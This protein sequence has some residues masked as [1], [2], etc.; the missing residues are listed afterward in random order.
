MPVVENW[1]CW[2]KT[3]CWV[4]LRQIKENK[5][6]ATC[7][8]YT[9]TISAKRERIHAHISKCKTHEIN[10]SSNTY[11]EDEVSNE[12][13]AFST[14]KKKKM[15]EF[16]DISVNKNPVI[17]LIIHYHLRISYFIK[18]QTSTT[19]ERIWKKRQQQS[20]YLC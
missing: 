10:S 3:V 8:F 1:K 12:I 14:Q 13:E 5:F 7:K 11:Y 16:S 2:R 20:S 19:Y 15:L 6:H 18:F 4:E 9:D 17:I